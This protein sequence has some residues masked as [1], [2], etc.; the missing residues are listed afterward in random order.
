MGSVQQSKGHLHIM[1]LTSQP[2]QQS[3]GPTKRELLNRN[4]KSFHHSR[5]LSA[6]L[7]GMHYGS[8]RYQRGQDFH[9][10]DFL[11]AAIVD[12]PVNIVAPLL[13]EP[14]NRDV[15]WH[16]TRLYSH[17]EY[18]PHQSPS[19]TFFKRHAKLPRS[20]PHAFNPLTLP[21]GSKI[22][23]EKTSSPLGRESPTASL[24]RLH[25]TKYLD[26][27]TIGDGRLFSAM[28]PDLMQ[29]MGYSTAHLHKVVPK[30]DKGI[31]PRRP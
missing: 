28:N 17:E 25:P 26:D 1:G 15:A 30:Q 8:S 22:R 13:R 24:V 31:S 7:S 10:R 4:G 18:G 16:H 9:L 27:D 20:G 5:P 6:T 11:G 21:F 29:R 12:P 2:G 19:P 14:R 23:Y 3:R